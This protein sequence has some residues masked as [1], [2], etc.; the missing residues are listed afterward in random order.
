VAETKNL[1]R[2]TA[3]PQHPMVNNTPE[4]VSRPN[5][6]GVPPESM[7][8]VLQVASRTPIDLIGQI[9]CQIFAPVI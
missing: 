5:A 7:R 1:S 3:P 8:F 2:L 6:L 9:R 4:V